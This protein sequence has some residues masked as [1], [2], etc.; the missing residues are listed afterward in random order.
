ME[1]AAEDTLPSRVRSA[2]VLYKFLPELVGVEKVLA[3]VIGIILVKGIIRPSDP[4]A[5]AGGRRVSV[6]SLW[7]QTRSI[8]EH[9]KGDHDTFQEAIRW[10][11]RQNLIFEKKGLH[12]QKADLVSPLAK[13]LLIAAQS[14]KDRTNA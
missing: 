4:S 7:K 12:L 3:T 14:I 10:M 13:P 11:R 1:Q 5:F 2:R 9:E 8:I 6:S